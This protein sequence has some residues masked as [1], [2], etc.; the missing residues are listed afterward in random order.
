MSSLAAT[1]R[2]ASDA[3]ETVSPARLVTML[4]DRL[5]TDLA[6]AEEAMRRGDIEATGFRVGHAQEILLELRGTLDTTMWP[7]GE[8]LASLYVWMVGELMQARLRNQPQR[9]ADC[10]DLVEPLREAWHTAQQSL[11]G[12]DSPVVGGRVDGAA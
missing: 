9:I 7:E 3:T 6:V 8:G 5:I 4:Y 10:R 2:Y 11:A 1:Q 12:V